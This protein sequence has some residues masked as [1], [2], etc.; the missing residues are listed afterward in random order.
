VWFE[1]VIA[2]PSENHA[3]HLWSWKHIGRP[4]IPTRLHDDGTFN[5]ALALQLNML[6]VSINH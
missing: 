2:Q 5:I 1:P 4:T 3:W 6:M